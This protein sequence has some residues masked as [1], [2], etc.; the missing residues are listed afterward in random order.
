ML[1]GLPNKYP[2]ALEAFK[3]LLLLWIF[4]IKNNGWGIAARAPFLCISKPQLL[5]RFIN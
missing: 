3:A 1:F 5:K 2:L 4:S